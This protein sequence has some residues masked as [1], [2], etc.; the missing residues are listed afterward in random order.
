M[1]AAFRLDIAALRAATTWIVV[2][3]GTAKGQVAQRAV[4][5]LAE[6]LVTKLVG[7][8]GDHGGFLSDPV[9]SPRRCTKCSPGAR[10][11]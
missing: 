1:W 7:F 9:P 8:P 10:W 3:G 6:A 11:G 2:G 5:A 4:V